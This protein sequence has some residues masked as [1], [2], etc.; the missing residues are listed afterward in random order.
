MSDD[1]ALG[2]PVRSPGGPGTV[3]T[4]ATGDEFTGVPG[5]DV[6]PPGAAGR[7]RR[8][9]GPAARA[10][11]RRSLTARAA[12]RRLTRRRPRPAALISPGARRLGPPEGRK[13]ARPG[14]LPVWRQEA[15]AARWA[16]AL[17]AAGGVGALIEDPRTRLHP[18]VD[19]LFCGRVSEAASLVETAWADIDRLRLLGV[20]GHG[21]AAKALI[22]AHRGLRDGPADPSARFDARCGTREDEIQIVEGLGHAVR[23]LLHG[24]G[25]AARARLRQLHAKNA[26]RAGSGERFD[27][28]HLWGRY[29]LTLLLDCVDGS[30]G[31]AEH[32]AVAA[33]PASRLPWN[34]L[35]VHLAD[36]VLAGREGAPAAAETALG[37]ALVVAAG[38]PPARHL[39]LGLVAR[40]ATRD[41]WGEP[42]RWLQ[43]AERFYAAHGMHPAVRHFR[44]QLRDPGERVRQRRHGS[45]DVPERLWRLGV[46]VREFEVLAR[47][48]RR[49]T[50]REIAAELHLSHRTVERHVAN[51]LEKT[52]ASN[53]RELAALLAREQ[54]DPVGVSG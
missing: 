47:L 23:E 20:R 16:T 22:R 17:A 24:A 12:N 37:R 10:L 21:P 34:A 44:S 28:H 41:G 36:A 50:N 38:C 46:T 54:R 35:L 25:E 53:R 52:Q 31:R 45:A 51:L 39:G 32:A 40:T 7:V 3:Q 5:E 11:A 18:A 49:R 9:A 43:E 13:R 48:G 26:D 42:S 8:S 15:D 14:A 19:A 33:H 4:R 27:T 29:G 6:L 1:Q 2:Q 30:A